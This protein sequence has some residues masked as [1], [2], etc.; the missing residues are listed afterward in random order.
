MPRTMSLA[1]PT[2]LRATYDQLA[3]MS[4]AVAQRYIEV[5]TVVQPTFTPTEF[6]IWTQHC[7]QLAQSGWRAWESVE[8]FL[9]L[10]P[11]LQQRLGADDLWPWAEHGVALARYSAEV[12]TAFFHAAKPL[13]QEASHTVFAP[14]VAG[15]RAYLELPPLL[16]LVAE[17]FRLSPHIYGHYALP[18][19][20]LWGQLGAD[21]ARAGVSY[22]QRF[23]LLSRTHLDRTPEIDHAP[24]W[25]FAQHCLPQA[26]MVALD[27]LERYATLFHYL[28]LASMAKVE[29]ILGD[30]LAPVPDDARIFLRLVGSTLAFMSVTEQLRALTWCQEIAAV[31]ASGV[32]DFLRHLP[33][34]QQRLPGQRL[35]PWV[36][37]GLD[38][39]RRHA[40]AGHAYFA[41]ESAAA[42]DRLQE[43]QS[44]ITFAHVEPILRLYTEALLGQ[45]MTLRTTADLPP[46]LQTAGRDLPT[47][48]GTAIFVPEHVSDFA[49]E[50]DNFAAYKVAIL[51]QV[52]FY[53]CGTLQFD[54][55]VCAQRVP[56]LRLYLSTL[57]APPGQAEAFAHFFA[58][59][60]QPDLAR[61]L[62][63]LLEDARIDAALLRRYKGIRRD[64]ALMMAH[65]LRQRPALQHLSLRQALLEGL[66]QRT[67]GKEMSDDVPALLRPLLQR[68]WQ[69]L[70]PLYTPTATVY[71]TAAAVVD[72][73]VLLTQIPTHAMPAAPLDTLTSLTDLAAQL[74]EDADTLA[75]ADMFR[76][77]G[78]GA[79]TMPMLPESAEPAK[80]TEP[81]PYRGEVK[82]E[83]IQKK[84]RL[85]ELAEALQAFEQG[86]NPLS[87]EALQELLKQG[88][89]DIKSLQAGDLTSTSGLFVTNLEGR[90]GIAPDPAAQQVVLQ[91]DLEALQTELQQEYGALAAQSQAFLYDEWDH[92]IGDYR[93][94]WCRLT[95]TT[96]DDEGSAFVE[97][98]RQRHTELFAQV[99]RQFQLLKPDTFQ[100]LKR[101]VDGEE[102]DLDSAIEA[103]VDRRASYTMPEKVYMRRQRRAR[104]V[105]AVFLLDMSA[106][107]DDVVKEPAHASTPPP[108]ASPPPRLYDFSGFVQDDHYYTLPPRAAVT[109]P[110]RRR[111]IDVEKEALVL[112]A[113]A[114]EGLGDAYA[115]YGF[116]GYGRD[117]VDFFVVK[118]F[119]ERYDA[120]VQG[121]IAAIKPHRS[122]RMGPAIRHAI[123]KFASQ[124][125]RVKLLLLLSD[126][127]PQD[128][129]YGKDRKSK[130]YGI[131]DT[132]MALHETRRQGIQTFCLTV[133]PAGHDYLRAMCPDQQYLVLEDIAS[134]PK[135]LPKV[136]RSLTT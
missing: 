43:L 23:F 102:I 42:Q 6:A 73:Y 5:A 120:R 36:T 35:Q 94:A 25:T 69:R 89:I 27:Y 37:T 15:S 85:Q 128:F 90:E 125:A 79:D 2:A 34:L 40:E 111:I 86:L 74:P 123:H 38:V 47:S 39:A 56:G 24:A 12:A 112:M 21:F 130:E 134:L 29:T 3:A 99:S 22:G 100:H 124:E 110:P 135:E 57:D 7:L 96:L 30:V 19:A 82:P 107:T 41:L 109:S 61:S 136:Y 49:T 67:L 113:E 4:P 33:D 28:G 9:Q 48:D 60:P 1:V 95:E 104:S 75:L 131:Q 76:Q 81:V 129:D 72:C 83:L 78:T 71:D 32:L 18:V 116:S 8:A 68:L 17:Y 26:P 91:Q 51:H 133:D 63:T 50:R 115:V 53:E 122:T 97:E 46:G 13:L 127:Y 77:A 101:L 119:M 11:F 62:F 105:A 92:I 126:G 65:S 58:A 118:E 52:G 114:L 10:S 31:S 20:T 55:T 44:R 16:A 80:G 132:T 66:L 117:Q 88:D 108:P 103:F 64:F 45:R 93:R 14:W 54:V 84:M 106:S 98:T 70:T 59:F 87:P 121:R